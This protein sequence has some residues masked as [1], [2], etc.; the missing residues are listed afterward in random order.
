MFGSRMGRS[1]VPRPGV[2]RAAPI[3]IVVDV[4]HDD[5]RAQSKRAF[6]VRTPVKNKRHR[7]TGA[8]L[9][10]LDHG[11]LV[12]NLLLGEHGDARF[13]K[14]NHSFAAILRLHAE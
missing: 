12:A 14:S 11:D 13:R 3:S 1:C 7:Y 10:V 2:L 5:E 9:D 6:R 4:L 8:V